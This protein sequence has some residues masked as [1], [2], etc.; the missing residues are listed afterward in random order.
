MGQTDVHQWQW[1]EP[2]QPDTVLSGVTG[3]ELGFAAPVRT[4]E[5]P[6]GCCEAV[7]FI[8]K[9]LGC[10]RISR[11]KPGRTPWKN[12]ENPQILGRLRSSVE[13]SGRAN[14]AGDGTV[15]TLYRHDLKR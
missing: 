4:E 7:K 6:G 8:E 9:A 12:G 2:C 13:A 14:G 1:E 11:I 3:T 10:N 15:K 5:D